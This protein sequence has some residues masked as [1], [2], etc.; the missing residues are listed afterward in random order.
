[1]KKVFNKQLN[2]LLPLVAPGKESVG[3]HDELATLLNEHGIEIDSLSDEEMRPYLA[4]TFYR[5]LSRR[6]LRDLLW[7]TQSSATSPFGILIVLTEG[8]PNSSNL[9]RQMTRTFIARM[10]DDLA[11]FCEAVADVI[12]SQMEMKEDVKQIP[13]RGPVKPKIEDDGRNSQG[14]TEDDDNPRASQGER[15][16]R[17]HLI[18][19]DH[20]YCLWRPCLN[21]LE[22]LL[23]MQGKHVVQHRFS[24]FWKKHIQL[25]HI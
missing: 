24:A 14:S 3:G 5:R 2:T 17:V 10:D 8:N 6:E 25:I 11:E 20:P 16:R 12:V 7:A 9:K 23:Q 18:Y 1:M 15:D 21:V 4:D 13:D 19:N 22:S